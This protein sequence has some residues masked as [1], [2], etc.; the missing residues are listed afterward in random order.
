[1]DFKTGNLNGGFLVNFT[2]FLTAV[3][4]GFLSLKILE[5]IAVKGK[6]HYF[7]VYCLILAL[8]ILFI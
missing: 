3:I 8:I 6:L 5:K 1:F 4:F 7:A 2:G